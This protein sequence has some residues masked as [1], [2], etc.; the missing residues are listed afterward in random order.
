MFY[1]HPPFIFHIG[2]LVCSKNFWPIRNLDFLFC[3]VKS[4][5]VKVVFVWRRLLHCLY[6][7]MR[8]GQ[9]EPWKL[10]EAV[11][12]LQ[13]ALL[14]HCKTGLRSCRNWKENEFDKNFICLFVFISFQIWQFHNGYTIHMRHK[15]YIVFEFQIDV[16]DRYALIY[17]IEGNIY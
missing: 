16:N 3:A 8:F 13:S 11:F 4:L 6:S 10:F 5:K 17:Y 2:S 15:I 14:F 1:F 9:W 12:F 7:W